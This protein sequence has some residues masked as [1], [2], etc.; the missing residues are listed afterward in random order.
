MFFHLNHEDKNNNIVGGER[1]MHVTKFETNIFVG[2]AFE[3]KSRFIQGLIIKT[4]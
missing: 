4:L 1:R 2:M 3:V